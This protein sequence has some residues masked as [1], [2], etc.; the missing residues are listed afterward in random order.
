MTYCSMMHHRYNVKIISKQCCLVWSIRNL[1]WGV[2]WPKQFG[3][4]CHLK[5]D[6]QMLSEMFVLPKKTMDNICGCIYSFLRLCMLCV[7]VCVNT[8]TSL[9]GFFLL[10][11]LQYMQLLS[12]MS[13]TYS[14][15]KICDYRNPNKCALSLEPGHISS[16]C[17]I[18][19]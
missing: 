10:P 14:K 12:D 17:L 9:Y 2:C 19:S 18:V 15:A 8:Y 7:C 4:C 6:T 13:S 3:P 5:T 16:K 11:L 1:S